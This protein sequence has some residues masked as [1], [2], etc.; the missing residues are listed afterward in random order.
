[1]ATRKKEID[2]NEGVIDLMS[3]ERQERIAK[4]FRQAILEDQ[5]TPEGRRRLAKS[6]GGRPS[7]YLPNAVN[8][9]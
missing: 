7:K 6:F 1:M 5:K 2:W 4:K 3:E 8:K 9:Q